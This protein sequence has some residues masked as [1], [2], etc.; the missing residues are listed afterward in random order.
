[1]DLNGKSD[2]D[3][4]Q[5]RFYKEKEEWAENLRLAYVAMTR[6]EYALYLSWD[7]AKSTEF[8]PL[9]YLLQDPRQS[10]SLLKN[11][12]KLETDEEVQCSSDEFHTAIGELC[13][14]HPDLF[15]LEYG[16][17][18]TEWSK[19]D[20]ENNSSQEHQ[21]KQFGRPLPLSNSYQ[22]SS[23][24]SLS[25]WMD[26]DDPDVPDYD[27]FIYF[28]EPEEEVKSARPEEQSMFTFPKGPQPG[29]CIHNIFE[30]YFSKSGKKDE[31]ITNQLQLNSIDESWKG[32]VSDML[33]MVLQKSLHPDF[34]GL[35]LAAV[36]DRQIPEM[37]FYYQN[38]EIETRKLLSII[39]DGNTPDW[40]NKGRAAS[41]FLKGFIDLT[42]EFNGKYYLLDYKTNYLGDYFEDYRQELLQHE[43]WEASYDLQYHIYTVALH[44]YLQ[45]RLPDYSYEH[46]FGGAFYLFLRGMNTDG[47]E[48]IFFDRPN[49]QVITELDQ[50]IKRGGHG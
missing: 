26:E 34:E 38:E 6:A 1:M 40:E 42:F 39:R 32:T 47:S 31:V 41:G 27:Q 33:E 43:M 35:S 25:S 15:T 44:R 49:K 48:G 3:R 45:K 2:P 21:V 23:F 37:E 13:E 46:D 18:S 5:K 22:I 20:N 14:Q 8:S 29:T 16:K 30:N 7:F 10:I 12:V 11:K 4:S 24:S 50:Y 28:E 9:G 36:K 19:S 17:R